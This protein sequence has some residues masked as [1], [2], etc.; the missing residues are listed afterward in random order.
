[1]IIRD[2]TPGDAP[3]LAAIYGPHVLHGLGSFEETP[4]TPDMMAERWAGVVAVGLPYLVAADGAGELLGFAYASPFRTRPA[5]RHTAE[6]SV[7]VAPGQAGRGVGKAL[8]SAVLDRCEALGVRQ[9][10]AIVGDSGNAASLALHKSLGF[11]HIGVMPALGFKHG[12]WVDI[13]LLQKPLGGGA[14]RPPSGGGLMLG[15]G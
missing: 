3:A 11:A 12:R 10:I 13:V 14:D 15:P 5:Y 2:A 9:M 4:P 8:L 6:D 7:Y 1:L